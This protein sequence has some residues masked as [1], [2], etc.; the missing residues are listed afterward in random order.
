MVRKRS[1]AWTVFDATTMT[2]M[3]AVSR[4]H[5]TMPSEPKAEGASVKGVTVVPSNMQTYCTNVQFT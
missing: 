5:R 2:S 4:C 1:M 3:A